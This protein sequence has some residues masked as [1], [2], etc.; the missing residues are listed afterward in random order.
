MYIIR[1][2]HLAVHKPGAL[3][4]QDGVRLMF[5]VLTV[6]TH[7]HNVDWLVLG[8]E[9]R[10]TFFMKVTYIFD[11]ERN[12]NY[13]IKVPDKTYRLSQFGDLFSSMENDV[14]TSL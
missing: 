10:R 11:S 5:S 14:F 1:G 6:Y 4:G 3:V 8:L 7:V 13:C 2:P 9:G 12:T